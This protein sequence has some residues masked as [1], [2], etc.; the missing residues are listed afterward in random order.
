MDGLLLI[1][2]KATNEPFERFIVE[3]HGHRALLTLYLPDTHPDSAIYE[4]FKRLPKD[5]VPELL[6]HGNGNV[7]D[8][9][10]QILS[11]QSFIGSCNLRSIDLPT[12][13]QIVK[14]IGRILSFSTENGL[15]HGNLRPENI[16][17]RSRSI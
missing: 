17:I 12:I 6:A 13:Q 14:S 5:Y 8:M 15:R 3:R 4:I 11:A 16:L 10:L 9:R 2:W 1:D 7:V